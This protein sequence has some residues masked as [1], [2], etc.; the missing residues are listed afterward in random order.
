MNLC[1][2]VSDAGSGGQIIVTESAYHSVEEYFHRIS[3][4]VD[5]KYL[6]TFRVKGVQE[7]VPLYQ[8]MPE[9]LSVRMFGALRHVVVVDTDNQDET[10]QTAQDDTFDKAKYIDAVQILRKWCHTS[11]GV[12]VN[13]FVGLLH[14][15]ISEGMV[16]EVQVTG[17][18]LQILICTSRDYREDVSSLSETTDASTT[19]SGLVFHRTLSWVLMDKILKSLPG[20]SVIFMAEMVGRPLEAAS[21]QNPLKRVSTK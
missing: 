10:S 7:D 19:V 15:S 13:S 17:A 14:Q 18:L 3:T 4:F 2:R 8:L 12:P 1:S 6:G 5:V 20:S 16:R 9:A 11:G 21:W